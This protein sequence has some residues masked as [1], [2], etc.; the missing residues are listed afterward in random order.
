MFWIFVFS[1]SKR[2]IH[3]LRGVTLKIS[4]PKEPI[5]RESERVLQGFL[6]PG[7]RAPRTCCTEFRPEPGSI[8]TFKARYDYLPEL[9]SG[10]REPPWGTGHATKPFPPQILIVDSPDLYPPLQN[11]PCDNQHERLSW[12][13]ER[14]IRSEI[15]SGRKLPSTPW[16]NKEQ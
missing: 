10:I 11:E 9:I 16:N 15:T 2:R 13:V 14:S 3:R 1:G 12:S 4:S 8:P 6:T 7:R 5:L